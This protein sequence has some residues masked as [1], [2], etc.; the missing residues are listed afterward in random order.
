MDY[1][2]IIDYFR[3]KLI[4]HLL[5]FEFLIVLYYQ[6]SLFACYVQGKKSAQL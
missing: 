5:D 6:L 3:E 1:F 4:D 2:L